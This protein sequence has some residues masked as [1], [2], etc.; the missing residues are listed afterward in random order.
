[1]KLGSKRWFTPEE[2][3]AMDA[4]VTALTEAGYQPN[5]RTVSRRIRGKDVGGGAL[6]FKW[7]PV[8][9]A[10]VGPKQTYFCSVEDHGEFFNTR[11]ID[12]A[13]LE[14]IKA[15]LAWRGAGTGAPAPVRER[16][17]ENWGSRYYR[18]G[19]GK[20]RTE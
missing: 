7:G 19:Y 10:T 4:V 16:T 3:V 20:R 12:T 15:E 2:S 5:G 11:W 6:K 17:A 14:A 8:E 9:R 1:M 13:N 18:G